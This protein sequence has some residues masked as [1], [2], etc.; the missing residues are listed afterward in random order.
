MFKQI[1]IEKVFARKNQYNYIVVCNNCKTVF[2]TRG[3][4][5]ARGKVC[6]CS[7]KCAGN[8]RKGI[9]V[10]PKTEIKKG[11]RISIKTEFKSGH[12]SW[13]TG[14]KLLHMRRENAC[15]WKGGRTTCLGYSMIHTSTENKTKYSREHRLVVEKELG[16]KLLGTEVVHHING[17]KTDNII[18]N[19]Y[20]FKNQSEHQTYHLLAK[21]NKIKEIT[22]SN[23]KN[24]I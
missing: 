23:I 6:F 18:S 19:L 10:S 22:K 20:L 4:L 14:K 5:I 3:S 15:H 12:K 9:R 1:I 13:S 16:R 17:D 8:A 11:Q 24:K 2:K 21:Y 7:T